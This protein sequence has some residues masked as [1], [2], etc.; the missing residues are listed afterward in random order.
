MTKK[1]SYKDKGHYGG[2]DVLAR[3]TKL[4]ELGLTWEKIGEKIGCSGD[5]CLKLFNKSKK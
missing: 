1:K 4:R 2:S 3:I 5:Y